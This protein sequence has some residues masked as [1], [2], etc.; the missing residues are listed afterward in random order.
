MTNTGIDTAWRGKTF[1]TQPISGQ[2]FYLDVPN[3]ND[4]APGW[5]EFVTSVGTPTSAGTW[6]SIGRAV[7]DQ[8]DIVRPSQ[9]RRQGPRSGQ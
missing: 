2:P 9:E 7:G 8:G 3:D 6:Q 5:Y 4:P 1:P